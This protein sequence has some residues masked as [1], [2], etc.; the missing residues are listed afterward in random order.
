MKDVIDTFISSYKWKIG[1]FSTLPIVFGVCMAILDVLMMSLGKYSSRGQ[2]PYGIALPVATV[3]YSLEPYIF[4]KS[5]KYESLTAMNLIWDLTSDVLVTILGVFWFGESI[6]GLRWIAVLFA[7][8]SLGLFAY[9]D[10]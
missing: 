10:E 4:F 2:I 1:K 9:T 3:I 8:F 5:L 7:I 6:K